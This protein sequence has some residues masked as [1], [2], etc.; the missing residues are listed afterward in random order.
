MKTQILI[1]ITFLVAFGC[2]HISS[3]EARRQIASVSL[4]TFQKVQV[5]SKLSL[6]ELQSARPQAS[7]EADNWWM[8]YREAQLQE[9][10]NPAQSCQ[11]YGRLAVN[12]NF[13]LSDLSWLRSQT[14]CDQL[15]PQFLN[16]TALRNPWYKELS[17]EVRKRHVLTTT[18]L[19]DD[20][21]LKT[22]EARNEDQTFKK[23]KLLLEAIKLAEKIN[24]AQLIQQ[25][26]SQ[27]AQSFPRYLQNPPVNQWLAVAKDQRQVRQFSQAATTYRNYIKN[28]STNIDE[29]Y[30]AWK[31]LR[32]TYKVAQMK[33]ELLAVDQ[34]FT[35]WVEK[36]ATNNPSK[37][38]VKRWHDQ[39]LQQA[40]QLWTEDQSEKA[41][42]L[43]Q[44]SLIVFKNK[45]SLDETHF[46][47]GRMKEEKA[48]FTEADAELEKALTFPEST[49]GL[50]EKILWTSTW[51][52]YKL[53][54]FDKSLE[55]LEQ[56]LQLNLDPS[57]KY[58]YLFW[59]A[60]SQSQL[61]LSESSDTYKDLADQDPLGF[62]GLL[63]YRDRQLQLPALDLETHDELDLSL[64]LI[65]EIPAQVGVKLDW[66]ILVQEAKVLEQGLNITLDSVQQ[67]NLSEISWIRFLTGYARANLYVRLFSYLP[68][69][70]S[71]TR[72]HLLK[73]HPELLFP[74]PYDE[75]VVPAA[76]KN[77]INP[78]FVYSIMRQE[79]AYN[80]EARSSADAMGL[81]QLLPT[82]AEQLA[83]QN[84]I[85]FNEAADLFKPEINIPLGAI[86][87][88]NL[89]SKYGR[90]T[91]LTACG[92]NASGKAVQGWLKNR[93]R[94]DIVEFIEEI[95]YEETRTYV[96]LVLRNHIFYQR[97]ASAQSPL[98]F[99]ESLMSW[100]PSTGSF[101]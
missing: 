7:S 26:K 66:L 100:P 77:S 78:F 72:D 10:S 63:S 29:K 38:W 6:S 20:F 33:T 2:S 81:L 91:V 56:I 37:V 39:L 28:T 8:D 74:R 12:K 16:H 80:P 62:Y 11:I 9:K 71:Q 13:P 25:A 52:N 49:A 53:K 84:N 21:D 54:K 40:R 69:I 68:K 64:S 60:R 19:Q 85:P 94:A 45:Y 87:M 73:T 95:P 47:I 42:Q 86:E 15:D 3:N 82:L 5:W 58:K 36:Q 98:D 97:L 46:I 14:V 4:P 70:K 75:Y 51:L 18:S 41:A 34:E 31:G 44:K 43:L 65:N 1:T 57:Q 30:E 32:A 22:E 79:S 35:T 83:Q 99:P 24:S 50:R 76:E 88:K 17:I 59:K 89:F 92:Y 23:E 61:N 55:R 101:R 27:L 90:N 93:F 96:K 67:Q 48:Q